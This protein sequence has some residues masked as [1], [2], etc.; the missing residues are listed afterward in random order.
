[1]RVGLVL[2]TSLCSGQIARMAAERLTQAGVGGPAGLTRFAALV[3]TEGCGVSGGPNE[4][5]YARTLLGYLTHPSVGAALLLEHGCEKTHND[6]M[7]NQLTDAGIDTAAF[8]YA[9]VQLDGGI[10]NALDRIEA[11]FR[12]LP[13]SDVSPTPADAGA[14]PD[15]P[16]RCDAGP[17]LPD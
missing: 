6:Y 17:K 5:I 3:H 1:M 15:R 2:P 14:P 16:P 13:A 12:A 11:W 8:G 10:A 9:S 7:Q 4:A